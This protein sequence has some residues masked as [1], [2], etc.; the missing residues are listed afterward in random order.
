MFG[1]V[2]LGAAVIALTPD[3]GEGDSMWMRYRPGD[4][5]LT[6]LFVDLTLVGGTSN[7]ITPLWSLQWEIIFSALLPLYIYASRRIHVALQLVIFFALATIGAYASIGSLKF[8]SMFGIGVAPGV[9]LGRPLRAGSPA[10]RARP[11]GRPLVA[12]ARRRRPDGDVVLDLRKA[13]PTELVQV[14]TL[15]LIL[16]GICVIIVAAANAPVLSRA[17]SSRVFGFLGLISFSLYLVHEPLVMAVAAV[18]PRRRWWCS[19]PCR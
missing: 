3:P 14:V 5:D 13:L 18:M 4:Y 8:L 1:A 16:A 10:C 9:G 19:S 2:L 7:R 12:R 6:G 15:P 17:L 11:C